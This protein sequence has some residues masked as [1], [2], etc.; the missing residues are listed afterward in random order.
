MTSRALA[1][2]SYGYEDLRVGDVIATGSAEISADLIAGFA[3]LTGDEYEL[4]LDDEAARRR[5]F[6]SRVAHGL[7]V[8]SVVD[9]LKYRSVVRLD[10]L[11]SLGWDWRFEQPV[12]AGDTIRAELNVVS[13]RT[14]S[15]GKRGIIAFR[16]DVFNQDGL[17]VQRGTNELIFDL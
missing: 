5:G 2:G 13:K 8:L 17:R 14:T 15:S 1:A 3:A 9:G 7:L 11:A 12:F 4:H 6:P 10:G 16:F